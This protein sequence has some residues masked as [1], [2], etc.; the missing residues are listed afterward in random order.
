MIEDGSTI[1]AAIINASSTLIKQENNALAGMRL[2][3][4]YYSK[5]IRYNVSIEL[6]A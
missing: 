2:H 4:R 3:Y 6:D 1:N 5:E